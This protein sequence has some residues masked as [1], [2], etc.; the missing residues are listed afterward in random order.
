MESGQ[1]VLVTAAS[2]HGATWGIAERIAQILTSAGLQV[3]LVKPEQV[4]DLGQYG[5]VVIGSAVYYKKWLKPAVEL[6]DNHM[7]ELVKRQVWLFSSGLLNNII[8]PPSEQYGGI[9]DI[10][11]KTKARDH[12]VFSGMLTPSNFGFIHRTYIKL[13]RSPVGDFRD[14]ND[15]ECWANLIAA[16]IRG[17][18]P[19]VEMASADVC[20][21]VPAVT[22]KTALAGAPAQTVGGA[23]VAGETAGGAAAGANG[24]AVSPAMGAAVAAVAASPI[25]TAA[26]AAS[27]A[28]P[29]VAAASPAAPAATPPILPPAPA[30]SEASPATNAAAPVAPTAATPPTAQAAASKTTTPAAK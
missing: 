20:L 7:D 27:P 2:E 15:I 13:S 23:A 21:I 12:K 24:A 11:N 22:A 9:Y 1:K 30:A 25:L 8:K 28:A 17:I 10:I 18:G 29:P 4:G 16:Q 5:A 19:A 6:V 14:W 26:P 3:D